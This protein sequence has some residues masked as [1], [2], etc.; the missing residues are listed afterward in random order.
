MKNEKMGAVF[1]V[2]AGTGADDLI[3][4]RSLAL[5]QSADAVVYDN[6]SSA[7]LLGECKAG[8]E[9]IFAGKIPGKHSVSQEK[10]NEILI[11]KAKEG[12][13]VVRLK[14]GDP[15]VFGRGGEE[16]A[17]LSAA[18]VPYALIPGV[19]S[20]IAVPELSGIP[21]TH[22]GVARSFRV[23]TA[24]LA[25]SLC[26]DY[27]ARFANDGAETLVFL[28]GVEASAQISR[29]LIAGGMSAQTPVAVI[30]RGSTPQSRRIDATL[31][32]LTAEIERAL[33]H[34]P[35]VIVV[36]K[37]AAFHFVSADCALSAFKIGVAGT[38]QLVEK[39]RRA[40]L[41]AGADVFCAPFVKIEPNEPALSALF[42]SG[43][44][45]F[46]WVIFTSS[47]GIELFFDRLA[48]SAL[49]MRSL[50]HLKFC[51]VG[52][53]SA[54]TLRAR[55]F[56][57]DFVP[58]NAGAK[59]L[60]ESFAKIYGKTA[61][62]VLAVRAEE[63]SAELNRVFAAAKIPFCDA[64]IYKTAADSELLSLFA[65]NACALDFVAFSSAFAVR[66][67]FAFCRSHRIN[68]LKDSAK[69]VCIGLSTLGECAKE[70]G[71]ERCIL[72]KEYT[73]EAMVQA[74][75]AAAEKTDGK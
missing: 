27:F 72:S 25:D 34:S 5:L 70:I 23:I 43:F 57:A 51:T 65:Q 15:F 58:E 54:K 44:S 7:A 39:Q 32:T 68:A 21:V 12:K 63:G 59:S 69:I 75:I 55:G 19:T 45:H 47:A 22:R 11:Q 62:S 50:S 30:E 14:G 33:V 64:H 4:V 40:F 71:E 52:K 9:K 29:G 66:A 1:L 2:G 8:A 56:I 38:K 61:K 24:H 53:A 37:T 60:A 67:F 31:G 16:A 74:L 46:D 10:I 35:A 48:Q 20:A 49:D 28:M 13:T 42:A 73:A 41:G 3:T 6:L 18:G 26:D 36:G 17:A